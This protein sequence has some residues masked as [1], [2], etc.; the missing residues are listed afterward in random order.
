MKD[1][2]GH[3][4]NSRNGMLDVNGKGIMPSRPF[5]EG[6]AHQISIAED[7]GIP[8]DHLHGGPMSSDP[9]E[10]QRQLSGTLS[11]FKS[12]YGGPRDHAAEA[13]SFRSGKRE[14]NRLRRQ[15]R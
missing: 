14:I 10:Y 8:T 9:H 3:G 4:S 5:R 13:R 6:T 7:H 2:Q 12:K 1:A 11:D 15:G